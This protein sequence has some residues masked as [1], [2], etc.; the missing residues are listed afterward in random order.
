MK[1][2]FSTVGSWA[3][4]ALAVFC[5]VCIPAIGAFLG[6]LGLSVLASS[7]V[8]HPLLVVFLGLAL[9]RFALGYRRHRNPWP[10]TVGVVGVVGLYAGKWLVFSMPIL[11]AGA[12]L[13]IASSL[14]D[15]VLGRRVSACRISKGG[16]FKMRKRSIL[17]SLLTA[18][19]LVWGAP[20]NASAQVEGATVKVDGLACPFCAYGLEKRLKKVEGVKKLEIK[21]NEGTAEI[22]VKKDETLSIEAVEKAVRDGGFT[23]RGISV[24]VTGRLAERDGRTMLTISGS[25]ETFLLESNEQLRKIVEALKDEEKAVRLIGKLSQERVEGHAGHPYVL[26]AEQFDVL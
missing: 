4:V 8:V 19:A 12:A 6:S 14:A 18:V 16:Y 25:E 21:V 22:T 26:T 3:S 11:Y 23:P 17:L 20:L 1:R 24:T 9:L 7:A 2:I 10:L 15:T 5:P 13:L